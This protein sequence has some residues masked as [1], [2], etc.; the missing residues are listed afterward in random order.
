MGGV[1]KVCRRLVAHGILLLDHG[2][3]VAKSGIIE[4][5]EDTMTLSGCS[6]VHEVLDGLL[7]LKASWLELVN[8]GI[9]D[10]IVHTLELSKLGQIDLNIG[11]L[12]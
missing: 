9:S 7:S 10:L 11:M 8:W 1:A 12:G 3:L 6:K 2:L 4:G 5:W